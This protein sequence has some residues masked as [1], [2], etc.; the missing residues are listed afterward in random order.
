[1][2]FRILGP[3]EVADGAAKL[4]GDPLVPRP[5]SAIAKATIRCSTIAGSSFGIRGL[6]RSRG[7]ST[8]SP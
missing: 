3:L 7:R 5:G 2:E 8:S 6:R 4:G 1:M